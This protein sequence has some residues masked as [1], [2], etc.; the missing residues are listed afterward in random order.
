MLLVN[1]LLALSLMNYGFA[2]WS[3]NLE[4]RPTAQTSRVSWGFD[5]NLL[6]QR[7]TGPDPTCDPGLENVRTCP[8]GKDVSKTVYS[9]GDAGSDGEGVPDR[10]DLTV[11]NAYPGYYN[12]ITCGIKNNGE[13]PISIER[14]VL[15]WEGRSQILESGSL[16][17]LCSGGEVV[18]RDVPEDALIEVRWSV[19]E[20]PLQGPG[21]L[22]EGYLEFH[23]LPGVSQKGKYNFSIAVAAA[24][25][26]D[27]GGADDAEEPGGSGVP[28]EPGE[29]EPPPGGDDEPID[30]PAEPGVV[31]PP[32]GPPSAG[33]QPEPVIPPPEGKPAFP[34]AKGEFPITG[35][36]LFAAVYAGVVL[37]GAGVLLLR[38]REGKR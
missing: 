8:E 34:P 21:E 29:P 22:F 11:S 30:V 15:G 10:I 18:C 13:V 38:R 25:D 19:E 26:E 32:A 36:N 1:M 35:G 23:I 28:G 14:A 20:K 3:G 6:E 24:V 9:W 5:R 37:I 16:Y 4:V 33:E 12:I 7:D 31:G 27:S 17:Y 2:R